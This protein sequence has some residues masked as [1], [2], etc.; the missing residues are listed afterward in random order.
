MEVK[1]EKPK[2]S[3]HLSHHDHA[4]VKHM[5]VGNK[6]VLKVTGKVKSVNHS[7]NEHGEDHN[8]HIEIDDIE[9]KPMKEKSYT[10]LMEE[11]INDNGKNGNQNE[12]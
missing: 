11:N 3:L 7:S 5:K 1:H 4:K 2:A 12:K 6:V 8:A 9:D 10:D